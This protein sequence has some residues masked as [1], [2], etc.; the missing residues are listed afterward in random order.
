M[1]EYV[2]IEGPRK[3]GIVEEPSVAVGPNQIKGR[4]LYSGISHGTEMHLYR[5]EHVWGDYPCRTGYSAV[6]E[7]SEVGEEVKA[8]KPGDIALSYCSHGTAFVTGEE[9][10]FPL[11]EGL[12]PDAAV[13]LALAG[14]AYNGILEARIALGETVVVFGLGVVGLCAS[15]FARRAGA[16]NVIG[17]DPIELRR[18]TAL[19]MGVDAVIDP[20]NEDVAAAVK[21]AN[22]GEDADI[23]IETSGA[24]AALN[25]ALKVIRQQSP[26]IALSWYSS[27]SEGLDLSRD[28]HFR[29]ARI[30]VAQASSIPPEL[31]PRWTHQRKVL[32]ALRLMPEM[33]LERLITHTF[34]YQDAAQAYELVDQH[35]EQTVQV[36]L[37]Y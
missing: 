15:F 29:R 28:F 33:G 30:R 21:D 11:P 2:V 19:G 8:F 31:S 13:I 17:I 3:V 34:A 7:V 4:M 12:R 35:P 14:V 18:R 9:S 20:A 16:F 24:I 32:S 37:Q 6:G 23:V 27:S 36:V 5:G 25:Q 26:I 1:P 22:A 10:A